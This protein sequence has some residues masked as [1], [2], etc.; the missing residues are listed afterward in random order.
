MSILVNG[1]PT[2]EFK[3][4]CGV[5]Q[6][7]PLSPFLFILAAE[8]LNALVKESVSKG[9]YN[10][11]CVGRDAVDVSYLQYADDTIFF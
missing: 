10:R 2:E 3:M 6:G 8:G 5:R 1:S 11:I 7:D 9:L 4:E